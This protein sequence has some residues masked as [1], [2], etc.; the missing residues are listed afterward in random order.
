MKKNLHNGQVDRCCNQLTRH[1]KS[2]VEWLHGTVV[3]LSVIVERQM[4]QD[5][6]GSSLLAVA[7]ASMR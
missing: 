3:A 1:I 2:K 4:T 7:I 6:P 5:S